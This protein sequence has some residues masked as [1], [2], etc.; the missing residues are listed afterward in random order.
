MSLR[1]SRLFKRAVLTIY[2][3]ALPVC[4]LAFVASFTTVSSEGAYQPSWATALVS[5][6]LAALI[7][8]CLWLVARSMGHV[9]D[10]P[11][12]RR[13]IIVVIPLA[14]LSLVGLVVMLLGLAWTGLGVWLAVHPDAF[15]AALTYPEGAISG[16]WAGG[17]TVGFGL[18]AVV[19][20]T[21]LNIPLL[22]L[23]TRRRSETPSP[24][25]AAALD[26]TP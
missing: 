18:I 16:R 5:G 23:L 3:I 19:G 17:L 7:G 11:S 13:W 20:G 2:W 24:A 25:D 22:R 4:L 15:D 10:L 8:W 26:T 9:G 14:L 21:A 6:A 12:P 1:S